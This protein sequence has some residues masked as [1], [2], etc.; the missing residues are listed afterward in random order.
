M[1]RSVFMPVPVIAPEMW[2]GQNDP[3]RKW[4]LKYLKYSP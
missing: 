2:V 3:I 4:S 1:I